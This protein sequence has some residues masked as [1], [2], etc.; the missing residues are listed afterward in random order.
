MNVFIRRLYENWWGPIF[1]EA[2]R[3]NLNWNIVTT[4]R[5][6]SDYL[7]GETFDSEILIRNVMK[8]CGRLKGLHMKIISSCSQ[9][10]FLL[11]SDR[12]TQR[13]PYEFK[14]MTRIIF[15]SIKER[16]DE[17]SHTPLRTEKCMRQPRRNSHWYDGRD[18]DKKYKQKTSINKE[19]ISPPPTSSTNRNRW[20]RS[21]KNMWPTARYRYAHNLS[22][23]SE[24]E[25]RNNVPSVSESGVHP[26]PN[27]LRNQFR[28]KK[29]IYWIS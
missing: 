28:I 2:G 1:V 18:E 27:S 8:R 10:V 16:D 29:V 22:S 5:R 25:F 13:T 19:V 17:S 21:G 7:S 14:K 23:T 9:R 20:R 4:V 3:N 11:R 12:I 26:C 15:I 24:M 6:I